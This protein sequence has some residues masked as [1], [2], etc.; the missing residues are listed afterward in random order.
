MKL[1][2]KCYHE[3]D[4]LDYFVGKAD[5]FEVQASREKN[6][7][8]LKKYKQ[9]NI[10]IVI[11]AEH[12]TQ[13]SNPAD[14]SNNS[15]N[16]ISITQA[17]KVADIADSKK[18]ILH[19]GVLANKFCSEENAIDFIRNIKDKR[20]LIENTFF[21]P[22]HLLCTTP[23]EMK[24]FLK[25]TGKKF[26]FDLAHCLISAHQH[27]TDPMLFIKEFLKLKPQH[28]HISGQKWNSLED[29]HLSLTECDFDLGKILRLYPK[30][31]EIT[32]E[33]SKYADKTE[34]DLKF[35]R[36]IIKNLQ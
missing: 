13:G 18:I 28:F 26:I 4:F 21:T 5:F 20:I 2:V 29:A 6:Y 14:I 33:V 1:G 16:Q 36:K 15:I 3:E 8:F 11:H 27:N 35:I 34:K 17:I 23:E 30:N 31:A 25:K 22:E 12:H 32:L 9:Y 24:A 10:P 7:N 19:P